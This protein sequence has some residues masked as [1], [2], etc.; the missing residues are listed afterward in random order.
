MHEAIKN[1]INFFDTAEVYTNSEKVLGPILQGSGN[2][3]DHIIASK[4]GQCLKTSD[5]RTGYT[6]VEIEKALD[7]SLQTLQTSYID[8]YQVDKL[9]IVT[10]SFQT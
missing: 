4:F 7:Q 3:K 5:G 8:L 9:V 6:A 2:R 1:G 10:D